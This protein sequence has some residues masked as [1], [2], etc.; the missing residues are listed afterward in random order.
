MVGGLEALK[1]T[2]LNVKGLNVPEK[3]KILM[4]DLKRSYSDVAYIQETHFR[5]GNV[6]ILKNNFYP[7]AYHAFNRAAKS[8]G[9]SILVSR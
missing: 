1:V 2:S 9:V 4:Q 8:R 7:Y 3:R 6:A 5:E